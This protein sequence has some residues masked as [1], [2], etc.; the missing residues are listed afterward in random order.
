EGS[1]PVC[2]LNNSD[3]SMRASRQRKPIA[4]GLY[5]SESTTMKPGHGDS[6]EDSWDTAQCCCMPRQQLTLITVFLSVIT[7]ATVAGAVGI[8]L[9]AVKIVQVASTADDTLKTSNEILHEVQ[10]TQVMNAVKLVSAA[11]LRD[12]GKLISDFFYAGGNA[13]KLIFSVEKVA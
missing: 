7:V 1:L 9:Q 8:W 13:T 11:M 5:D 2:D 6:S 4:F 10:Q 3:R 12:G